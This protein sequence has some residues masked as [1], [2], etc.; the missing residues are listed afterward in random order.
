MLLAR[1]FDNRELFIV[2]IED[3]GEVLAVHRDGGVVA[4]PENVKE[5]LVAGDIAV[6]DNLY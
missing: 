1:L 5:L 3:G 2:V 6:K 4:A